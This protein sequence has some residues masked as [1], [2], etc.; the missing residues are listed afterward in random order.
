VAVTVAST[1]RLITPPQLVLVQAACHQA[2]DHIIGSGPWLIDGVPAAKARSSL[3]RL[4]A[5]CGP[6]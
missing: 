3:L 2:R 4:L 1:S 5:A 6:S